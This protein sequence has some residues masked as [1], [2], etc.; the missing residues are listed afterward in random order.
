MK[1]LLAAVALCA[2]VVVPTSAVTIT[3]NED[4]DTRLDFTATEIGNGEDITL[5]TGT[6]YINVADDKGVADFFVC[7]LK[8]PC[9]AFKVSSN[10]EL[11][12]SVSARVYP[13]P[14]GLRFVY[15]EP[16]PDAD[17][18]GVPDE[19]DNCPQVANADQADADKDGIG[20]ACDNCPLISNPDQADADGDGIGDAC[21]PTPTDS[22][23]DGVPDKYD[24]CPQVANAD[25]A[26]ADGD[27]IG[28]VCDF[29]PNDAGNDADGDGV[30]GDVDAFPN[31]RDVGGN[32][33]IGTCDTGVPNVVFADGGTISDLIY[34]IAAASKNHGK[35]VSGVA[36]LKNDLRKAGVLT[37]M[38]AEAIQDC[39]ANSRLP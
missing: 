12:G 30:C 37:A 38:Q 23:N 33:M 6:Y 34:Q 18:D 35:F 20:D 32:V 2:M 4:S 5:A 17:N 27:G 1:S 28:D 7:Y 10:L 31:S 24:N 13:V 29:C 39:A 8:Q 19:D 9:D 26:D 14:G 25:Q 15:G 36:K 11:T 22:D 21:E 16:L 3:V